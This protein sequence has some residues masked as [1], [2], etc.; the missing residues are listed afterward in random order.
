MTITATNILHGTIMGT[1][2]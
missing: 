2:S 1:N